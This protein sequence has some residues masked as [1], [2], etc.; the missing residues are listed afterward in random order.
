M[1][2]VDLSP[3]VQ[4]MTPIILAVVSA[5]L[6]LIATLALAEL[7]KLTGIKVE[8]SR[9]KKVVDYAD[10][11]AKREILAA[12]GNLATASISV[13]SPLVAGLVNE[14]LAHL[15]FELDQLDVT[16][17]GVANIVAGSLGDLQAR[18]T[19]ISPPEP[20]AKT[21]AASGALITSSPPLSR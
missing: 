1:S 5:V 7:K 9:V 10:I 19:S 17:E 14:M 12:S 3:L 21:T 8:A 2:Q 16:P 6:S 11:L 15:P 13:K 20:P 18:M 4:A